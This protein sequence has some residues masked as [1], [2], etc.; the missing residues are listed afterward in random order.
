MFKYFNYIACLLIIIYIIYVI[1]VYMC[2]KLNYLY[3]LRIK[4]LNYNINKY[5][6]ISKNKDNLSSILKKHYLIIFILSLLFF[7]SLLLSARISFLI[8]LFASIEFYYLKR[9]LSKL[10]Q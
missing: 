4:V 5:N 6:I 2:F 8:M 3:N 7:I 10:N 9:V 1:N